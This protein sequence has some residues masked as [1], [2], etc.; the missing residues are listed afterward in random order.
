MASLSSSS[1]VSSALGNTALRGFGGMATG[2]DRDAIIEQMTLGTNTKIKNQESAITK[3]EWKQE[4]FR[5]IS[6]KIIDLT[7]NYIS[8]S[9]GANLGN[10]G[11]FA[12]NIISLHGKENSTRFV[13]ATGSSELI[14]N[15]SIQAVKQLASASVQKSAARTEKELQ[16]S[17]NDLNAITY[18]SNLKGTKLEFGIY[19]E[20][21]GWQGSASF[22]FPDSYTVG[23][24]DDKKTVTIDYSVKDEAGIKQ[25][26][27]DLNKALENSDVKIGDKEIKE[28]IKFKYDETS[29]KISLVDKDGNDFGK[30]A[31]IGGYGIKTSSSALSALGYTGDK[32][33][34]TMT[35]DSFNAGVS[36]DFYDSAI[37]E[38]TNLDYL[39]GKKVTFN[40]DGNKKDIELITKE[41]AAHL[42]SIMEDT[43]KT[44]DEKK[45][46]QME[47]W[48]GKLQE[49]LDKNFGGAT[50]SADGKVTNGIQVKIGANGGLS[51][52]TKADSS[53]AITTN[54]A[55]VLKT[56]GI[57]NGESNKVNMSGKLNQSGLGIDINEEDASGEKVYKD[58]LVINGVT[59][60]GIDA[61]TSISTILSKINSS[62][63]GVKATYVSATGQFMLVSN[64]TGAGRDIKLDSKLAQ[65]LFG[66][67]NADGSRNMD[68]FVEGKN[69]IVDISY[70]NG[71]T[72]QME[73]ASN[74]FNLEGLNVTVSGI[75]GGEWQKDENGN[76]VKWI[77]DT[78]GSV[79]FSAKADVDK[80]TETVKKFFEEFN[81]LV[82]EV[83]TQITTRPDSSYGPL[84]D[85]QMEEMSEK[86]IENW[87]KKAKAGLLY[88]DSTMRELS[89]DIQSI[90]T[91]MMSNGASY[92]DLK[93]MGITY[94]EDYLDGGKLVFDE[95]AFKTAME[96]DPEKVANVFTGGGNVDKGMVKILDET[97]TP[98][99]T[100]Y[101]S[102]NQVGNSQG[103]YGRLIEEAGSEKVPTSILKNQI[104]KDIQTKK[105]LI[106]Q[107]QTK[108]KTEQ[109]R[110]I[111]MFTTMETM[112]NQ[113][114]SQSSWLSQLG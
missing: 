76:N 101:A 93:E 86:S 99:A 63:A 5:S 106:A 52:A 54:D 18:E 65:D 2:I 56:L 112:I 28:A 58:G 105:D 15:V 40:Y 44:E 20:K 73:R 21:E 83:N 94:S 49:R 98:Y 26:V 51:F 33:D 45:A 92:D 75:F 29:K 114:N 78:S 59:I 17:M 55:T 35:L 13:T 110:Y 4:A 12:K 39:A 57:G 34:P 27:E 113:M 64:E 42:K 95:T 72:V 60:G 85:E 77:E 1:G 69:S 16:F 22:T 61:N 37:T 11:F 68:D 108:L 43:T 102:K 19:D 89:M 62:K 100:R 9:S 107:L 53:V 41:E 103:S 71:V 10:P 90:F 50:T 91:K 88:N 109:D 8:Y 32:K 23:E 84:T 104:Y 6:D 14:N 67:Y 87:E 7:D 24:G 38:K 111:S 30:D 36:K 3:L 47:Y 48:Q 97:F 46:A 74:T 31:T 79:T 25:L 80:V 70:G 96:N 81:T 82:S 66:S